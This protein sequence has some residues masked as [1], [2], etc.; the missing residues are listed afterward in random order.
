MDCLGFCGLLTHWDATDHVDEGRVRDQTNS[1]IS[2]GP[3]VFVPP[4]HG[5]PV[6]RRISLPE[7]G[8]IPSI[9]LF[10]GRQEWKI[11]VSANFTVARP[12]I[13]S[14]SAEGGPKAGKR[15]RS[16]L[17]GDSPCREYFY[18]PCKS[19]ELSRST[20]AK[21]IAFGCSISPASPGMPSWHAWRL[22]LAAWHSLAKSISLLCFMFGGLPPPHGS[23]MKWIA[24]EDCRIGIHSAGIV[25]AW[26]K[27]VLR[28]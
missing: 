12:Q 20:I 16:K 28:L 23:C 10:P 1:T 6:P 18:C 19:A 15:A 7:T 26:R 13:G 2:S 8:G 9:C 25:W 3:D 22:G 11:V 14:T 5:V 4:N 24:N 27:T 21:E 17:A